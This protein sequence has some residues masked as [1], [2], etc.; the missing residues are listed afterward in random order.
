MNKQ[1]AENRV[2][3]WRARAEL[4]RKQGNERGAAIC[5]RTVNELLA[6]AGRKPSG[7]LL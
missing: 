3:Y 7:E 2:S 6:A 4:L 5:E 1:E